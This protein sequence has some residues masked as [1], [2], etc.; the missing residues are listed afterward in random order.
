MKRIMSKFETKSLEDLEVLKKD[1]LDRIKEREYY[2]SLEAIQSDVLYQIFV[3]A[4]NVYIEHLKNK[5]SKIKYEIVKRKK[6][7]KLSKSLSKMS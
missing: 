1:Y 3:F 2:N 6:S 7:I 4:N 5:L